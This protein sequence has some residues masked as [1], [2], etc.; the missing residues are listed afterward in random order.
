MTEN[1]ETI[2]VK[3]RL[4]LSAPGLMVAAL[5]LI[6]ISQAE[7]T[8]E[9]YTVSDGLT[10]TSAVK[11]GLV[12]HPM[13][14]TLDDMGR[15]FVA[16]SSG[17]NLDKEE[18]LK[19]KPHSIKRL[20]DTD[21]DGVFDEA[22]TF[23]D[24]MTFPQGALWVYD[25]LYVMSPPGLWNLQD[26]DDDGI[27]DKREMI[28]SGFD[29]TG[30]AADVHGPFLHPN[31]RLYW[32]HGRKGHEV[33][34]PQSGK[35][36][37]KAK[38]ARIWSCEIDGSDV[39]VH[40]G[41]GMDNPVEVDFT[42]TGEIIGSV[43]LFYGKPRGDTLVHWLYGGAYPRRDQGA[44]LAEFKR[45]GPLLGELH[46][47][48][49]VAVSGMCRYRS[50][51]LN[52]DWK[53]Q[54]LVSHFNSNQVTMTKLE[55]SGSTYEATGTETIFQLNRPNAHLTDVMEDRNGDLLVIDTGGWFRKG[56]PSSQVARPE[57]A[58]GIYRVSKKDKPYE[59]VKFPTVTQW[60][61]FDPIQVAAQIK[62][63]HAFLRDRVVTEFAIRGHSSI[64][65]I[66]LILDDP[67]STPDQRR[68]CVWA[69]ARM[70][71]SDSPDLIRRTLRD[72]DPTVKI[73]ACNAF[74]VTRSWQQIAE[75]EPN[76][77]IYELERNKTI[78]GA[79]ADLV[80]GGDPEVARNAAMALGSMAEVR[81]IG[82]L[83]GR[84]G[85]EGV[86]RALQHAITYALIQ[87][88]D[89]EPVRE[90]L[91]S[92]NAAQKN[93]ALW[94]LEGME[95]YELEFLDV[96]LLLD[97]EDETLRKTVAEIARAH[98]EWDGAIANQ[99]YLFTDE[100]T[101]QKEAQILELA[102]GF[103]STPPI[104]SFVTYLMNHQDE[105]VSSLA[106]KLLPRFSNYE[107]QK[108]WEEPFRNW[109]ENPDTRMV[110]LD[111]LANTKTDLFDE[112]LTFIAADTEVSPIVRIKALQ[113]KSQKSQV[114]SDAA[115]ELIVDILTN[116]KDSALR[117][118]AIRILEKSGLNV[119]QRNTIAGML[120]QADPV[121]LPG[122]FRIFRTIPN[123]EQAK[124]LV[125]TLPK[126]P[127]F[128]GL[129]MAEVR[130][131]FSGFNSE[132]R[133]AIDDAVAKVEEQN[134]ARKEKLTSLVA[135][136]E[137]GDP[138]Q[139]KL[140]FKAGKGACIT[141]HKIGE[142]G[143]MIGPDL[144]KLGN[145]RKPVDFIESILYPSESIARD[146]ESYLVTLKDDSQHI[147]VI[148]EETEQVVFLTDMT[149]LVHE[150]DRNKIKEI[151][152][153][154]YSL[155]PVGLDQSMEQQELLDLV[156][157]LMSLK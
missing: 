42:E 56:C 142:E 145:I 128:G 84:V 39:R 62:T 103:T 157:Y 59:Q 88:E 36:V 22:T 83:F 37:S 60:E 58:G 50:G 79:L 19:E 51:A 86:D 6:N 111:S 23:A 12:K 7:L 104:L 125:E 38:G 34:D 122:L 24:G 73:A 121:E 149:G 136:I 68:A 70:R 9:D 130:G 8:P 132:I 80:R 116:S 16:E 141:C 90:Q 35:L 3:L 52:S 124:I 115:F 74:A 91:K 119:K 82:S 126:S 33:T 101:P 77:L 5:A 11:P 118:T 71:F 148:H 14:T 127:G 78:S 29:F 64:P 75:N 133:D 129:S 41:G 27:A 87:M 21:G 57:V 112:D 81:S 53:D 49:H 150:L 154:P 108:E 92:G 109:L 156:S 151:Q 139:G 106:G 123:E 26:T 105:A 66:E 47:F 146:Y 54:W 18:L 63:E 28:V 17:V 96:V 102:P 30:N 85:R 137:K 48:G 140:H 1:R 55:K 76:E 134:E 117:A 4:R 152:R 153:N 32:C 31:G 89:P 45:T 138:E 113:A 69:L 110:A 143:K 98:P 144:S 147:G 40:A 120:D 94:A 131:K 93:V 20:T 67:E 114:L 25:S 2:P 43:N 95:E 44:V 61:A 100:L 46:N 10:V 155:M 65:E 15:L 97:S 72:P 135:E 13:M 107:F 99:F